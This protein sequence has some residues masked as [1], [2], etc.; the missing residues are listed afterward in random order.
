MKYLG[1]QRFDRNCHVFSGRQSHLTGAVAI[2]DP[3]PSKPD[4]FD[5]AGVD[6]V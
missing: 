4:G 1:A 3:D 6:R 2:Y 5:E